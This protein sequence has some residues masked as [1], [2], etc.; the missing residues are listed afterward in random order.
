MNGAELLV[1]AAAA[2]GIEYCFANPGTTEIPLVAA[3]AAEPA[4]KPVLSLFE[5]VCTGAADGYGRI[6]GKPAMTLTHLGPG[7][8]NGIANLHNA[9]RANT[10]IVNVIGDHASWHVNY[11]PPLA[12]DI[13]ALARTVSGWVR[14][15]RR[16]A[17]I[18]EDFL[19]AVQAAWQPRGQVA[20]LVLP[21][22]LQAR[23]I[24]FDDAFPKPTPPVRRF[25]SDKVEA[26]AR[27]VRA[28]KRL[29]FIVGD[30]GLSV[31]GLQAAGRLA[32]L[33]GVRLFAETFPRLSYRGGGLPDL[34]RLPYFPEVAIEILNQYDIVVCA[35]IPEPISYFGYEGIPSRLAERDRLLC[36]A[37][38]GD[39]V[40]GAL[41]ALAEMLD[42]PAF[43]P[44]P[45]GVELPAAQERLT[46]QSVG[47]VLAAALPE[48]C[49]V[50]VEGGTC[51]YP[52]FTA[53]ANAARHRVLTNTGGAIGQGIPVGF[54]AALAERG[55][56]VFCLQSDGSAQYT[57]QTLW[58]IA[59][60]QLPVVILIAANHRYAILQNELRRFG[61]S[62]LGPQALALTELDR[63]RVDWK[64][65]A[66]GYGVPASSVRSNAE[67]QR[68]LA[69]AAA[70]AGPCLI[71]MEL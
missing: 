37:E 19:C 30:E 9:R 63:P 54:G 51:G 50:S 7:F 40:S 45:V 28:G 27:Q 24:V 65:L 29:V 58:S 53:S 61:L 12:S 26:V 25:A 23:D 14:T 11:D 56:R 41:A 38:V 1:R 34:D 59:R 43:V 3:M 48:D 8:A 20:S 64:A 13:E 70:S 46:P 22:D 42:A 32:G 66:K 4:L 52:F 5:G 17:S 55:N 31:A 6:A 16:A 62:E 49:I 15:S 68:A 36:L 2:S 71:E 10:P 67:L 18:G 47:R 39:D 35:G 69:E 60:E 21:M 57:I 44:A 33:P